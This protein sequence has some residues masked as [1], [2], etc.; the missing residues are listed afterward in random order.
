MPTG[1][2]HFV[3]PA[4][5]DDPALV[6]GGNVYDRRLT[7]GLSAIGWDV[8]T[9]RG[10]GRIRGR[11]SERARGG[12][13]RR[14]G[15]HRRPRRGS[16]RRRT[17]GRAS[18]LRLVVLAHMV[19]ASFPG[20]DPRAV[21]DECRALR[22]ARQVI[23]TSPW[24]RS[25]LVSRGLVPPERIV[26][27]APGSDAAPAGGRD[28]RGRRAAVRRRRLDAQRPGHSG[29][30]P[31]R[32]RARRRPGAARSSDRSTRDPAFVERSRPAP[33]TSG[34]ADRIT[35]TGALAETT[36][37]PPTGRR[38]ARRPVAR[39]ELRHGDRRRAGARHPRGR[40]QRRRNPADR[41]ACSRRDPRAAG[42]RRR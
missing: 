42:S 13:R 37:M 6:S 8:R 21:E 10:R 28:T 34:V 23:V 19:S 7:D 22:A 2:V 33:P 32:A 35:M 20:A 41:L 24:T 18:R 25:E 17:R 14:P 36:W 38:P 40:Q 12:A 11:G 30:S 31:R 27:A 39:R 26:V 3:V 15:A 29:R 4:G 1:T 5:I 9:S 16:R